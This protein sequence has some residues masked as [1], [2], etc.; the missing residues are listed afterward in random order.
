MESY[1]RLFPNQDTM[2]AGGFGNLVALPLQR[3]RR[4]SGCAG[5]SGRAVDVP[6]CIAHDELGCHATRLSHK[7]GT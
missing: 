1:D 3:A 4:A 6:G 7:P 2:P 5:E